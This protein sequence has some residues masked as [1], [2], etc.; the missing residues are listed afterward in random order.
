MVLQLT[1]ACCIQ[2]TWFDTLKASA[3]D[4]VRYTIHSDTALAD[5]KSIAACLSKGGQ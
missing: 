5:A 2:I 4:L 3:I 1:S